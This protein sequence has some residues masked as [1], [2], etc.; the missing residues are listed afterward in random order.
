ML[1]SLVTVAALALVGCGPVDAE[2]ATDTATPSSSLQPE[3][4]AAL[5]LMREEEK[6]ARDV[7]GALGAK[8]GL[9][10]FTNIA[11]SEQSH[12]DAVLGLLTAYH[13][14]DPAAG[15][16]PGVFTDANLQALYGQLVAQGSGGVTDALTV[17]ARI[18]ELDLADLARLSGQTARS[19][20][21]QV[22]ANLMKGSRNHLRSFYGQLGGDYTPQVLDEATFTAIVTSPHEAGAR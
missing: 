9:P 7:Y 13:L 10:L 18:E 3:E 16:G 11:R 19:D 5:R 12:M 6:L 14:E 22:Y 15:N 21:L 1:K 17:G 8:W 4:V 20:V 2:D